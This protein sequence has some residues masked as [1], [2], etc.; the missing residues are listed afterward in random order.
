MRDSTSW[1]RRGCP[2]CRRWACCSRCPRR[3]ASGPWR[4][5]GRVREVE[6]GQPGGPGGRGSAGCGVRPADA[7]AGAAGGGEGGGAVGGRD[8]HRRGDGAADARPLPAGRGAGAGGPP[9]HP[10]ADGAVACKRA[11]G[12]RAGGAGGGAGAFQRDTGTAAGAHRAAA[13]RAVRAG[14]STGRGWCHCPR[15]RRSTGSRTP[16]P[17]GAGCWTVRGSAAGAQRGRL[18]RSSRRR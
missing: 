1:T 14:G 15:V 16:S 6:T 10:P 18:P 17:T 12:G 11:G 3:C 7:D 9:C 4:G 2:G 5:N 8:A 13:G